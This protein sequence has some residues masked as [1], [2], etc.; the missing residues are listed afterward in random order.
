MTRGIKSLVD[1]LIRQNIGGESLVSL[2]I[3]TKRDGTLELNGERFEK[4]LA[5][6]PEALDAIFKGTGSE[7]GLL[8]SL[9]DTKSGLAVY[10][11]SV[12]GLLKTRKDSISDSLKRVDTE[13]ERVD[14]QYDNLY[15]RYLKQYTSMM[16]IMATMEQT[17]SLFFS[18]NTNSA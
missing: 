4:M 5:S 1:N 18:T 16:Q 9:L 13:Y 2:G 14:A 15:Q 10:T 6:K 12:N 7:K 8:D 3:T 11:N 17:S